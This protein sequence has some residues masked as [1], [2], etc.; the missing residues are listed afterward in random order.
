MYAH[1]TKVKDGYELRITTENRPVGGL[2][3]HVT[4]KREARALAREHNAT[5]W[6]F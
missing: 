3:T 6:N 4:G 1:I 2:V 5:P